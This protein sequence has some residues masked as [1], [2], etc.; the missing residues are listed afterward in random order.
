M[1]LAYES[2]L[3]ED[4]KWPESNFDEFIPKDKDICKDIDAIRHTSRDN[5]TD[6]TGS[7]TCK[8]KTVKKVNNN[9][10]F[11]EIKE[12]DPKKNGMTINKHINYG[13]WKDWKGIFI[14]DNKKCKSDTSNNLEP[15]DNARN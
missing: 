7:G 3:E 2:N 8:V 12:E 11:D 14:K 4:I 13:F 1:D 5:I 15:P 6:N 10:K 9:I